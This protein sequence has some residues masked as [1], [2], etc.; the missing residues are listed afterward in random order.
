M[1]RLVHASAIFVFAGLRMVW[2]LRQRRQATG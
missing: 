1:L 2:L